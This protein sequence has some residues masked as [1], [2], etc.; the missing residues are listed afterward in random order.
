MSTTTP[1]AQTTGSMPNR[2]ARLI[3]KGII[4]GLA[5]GLAFGSIMAFVGMLPMV[6][7]LIRQENA[8]VGFLV[9]M[10]I[11]AIVGAG[12]GG[13]MALYTEQRPMVTIAIGLAYGLFWWV[14]GALFLMPILL[15]MSENIF[16]VG[17]MQ[18]DSLIGHLIYG[19]V[20]SVAVNLLPS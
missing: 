17:Q 3:R 14:F 7:M 16:V 19:F 1:E 18:I 20:V 13:V 9:H 5:G 10:V 2:S 8:V 11:S 6:G 4:A 15:G 12:F